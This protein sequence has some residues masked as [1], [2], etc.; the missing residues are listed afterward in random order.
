MK[1]GVSFKS[2]IVKQELCMKWNR[3]P[4]TQVSFFYNAV[5]NSITCVTFVQKNN[6]I[7]NAAFGGKI[8]VILP[9]A[10]RYYYRSQCRWISPTTAGTLLVG[11][12]FW[13]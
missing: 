3:N 2:N 7:A 11:Y 9:T 13:L 8:E 5:T 6:S 4:M 12:P 10:A 1:Y